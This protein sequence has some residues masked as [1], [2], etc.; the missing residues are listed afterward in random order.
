M[1]K[2]GYQMVFLLW[3]GKLLPLKLPSDQQMWPYSPQQMIPIAFIIFQAKEHL[4]NSFINSLTITM[5]WSKL[6]IV[7]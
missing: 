1:D 6:N 4:T 5:N 3:G 2:P 7:I